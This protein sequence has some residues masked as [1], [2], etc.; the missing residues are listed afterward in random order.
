MTIFAKLLTCIS[1]IFA[2]FLDI[3]S[4]FPS[5]RMIELQLSHLYLVFILAHLPLRLGGGGC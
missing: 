5:L 4:I 1:Q 3:A 2:S